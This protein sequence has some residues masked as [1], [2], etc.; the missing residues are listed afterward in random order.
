[1]GVERMLGRAQA[2]RRIRVNRGR[3]MAV[4]LGFLL[5]EKAP[6][7]AKKA[8]ASRLYGHV[9]AQLLGE[10]EQRGA[11]F[12]K[13][14][15]AP[16]HDVS[17]SYRCPLSLSLPLSFSLSSISLLASCPPPVLSTPFL[18]PSWRHI[19]MATCCRPGTDCLGCWQGLRTSC[20]S[21]SGTWQASPGE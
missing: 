15:Q 19:S 21:A 18:I 16:R 12:A 5:H 3:Q 20:L 4:R 1:M 2:C 9:D 13:R 8:Q 11:H 10:M 17:A 7:S 14:G 6:G